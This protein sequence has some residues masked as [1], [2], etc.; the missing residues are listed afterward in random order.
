M[1]RGTPPYFELVTMQALF[2]IVE[3]SHPPIP[4]NFTA[5]S[6]S[7]LVRSFYHFLISFHIHFHLC[8]FGGHVL[9]LFLCL[10]GL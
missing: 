6:K 5:D 3:D 4:A 9:L 8:V 1:L 7:F 10:F 2:K